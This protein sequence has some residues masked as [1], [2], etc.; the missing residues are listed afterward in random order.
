MFAGI[1]TLYA[2]YSVT[3]KNKGSAAGR[4]RGVLFFKK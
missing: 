2:L 4:E 1:I 3:Q